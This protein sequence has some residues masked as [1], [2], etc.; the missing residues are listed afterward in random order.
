[1]TTSGSDLPAPVVPLRL[2]ARQQPTVWGGHLLTSVLGKPSVPEP[3]G[4][5][6]EI[7][8]GDSVASAPYQGLT[9]EALCARFPRELLGSVP[10]ERSHAR[11][12]LLTKFIDAEQP[13]SVQVHPNDEQAQELEGQPNGKTEAWHILAAKDGAWI[14]HGLEGHVDAQELRRRLEAG[15]A[16][17]LLHKIAVKPG[18]TVFMP[19]GTIHAIGPG[20][21][22]HEVQQTSAVTYRLYDWNRQAQGSKRELHL[23]RGL[24]V[25]SLKPSASA[26]VKTLAWHQGEAAEVTM[27]LATEYFSVK[28]LELRGTISL[29]TRDRSFHILTALS[30]VV[31]LLNAGE[32]PA[33]LK[34]GESLLVPAAVGGYD[35]VSEE[36]AVVLVE[37]VAD[38]EAEIVPELRSHGHSDAATSAF[39]EQFVPAP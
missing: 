21:L 15:T 13:L 38:I 14:I 28:R 18:D 23:D 1:M 25:S 4:E 11:F 10:L 22:L 12:P 19:A 34:A 8:E 17:D 20:V 36:G 2:I 5:S 9:L 29:D 3:V 32:A 37:Y 35:L 7:W 30:G 31:T 6:W 33:G 24:S 39:V 27:L 26:L 16:D